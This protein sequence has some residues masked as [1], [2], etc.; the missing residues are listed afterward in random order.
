MAKKR[1][2]NEEIAQLRESP[3]VI[4]VTDSLVHFSAE[5][6]QKFWEAHCTGMKPRE[7]VISLGIDPDILGQSRVNAIK[8]KIW[9]S[10]KS[11]KG[12]YDI[13]TS[14]SYLDSKIAPETKI[15][16][17]EQQLAYKEQELEFLKKIV[18]LSRE[19]RES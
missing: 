13:N 12:F 8:P 5:F 6:K 18:S 2:T 16:Y 11:G 7:I 9:E 3:Y 17:L 14:S 15:K 19:D 4:K 1:F 10:I